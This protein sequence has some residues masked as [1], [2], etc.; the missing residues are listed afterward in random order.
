MALPRVLFL[1]IGNSCRSQMAEGYARTYGSDVMI[2]LSAGLAPAAMV[3]PVTLK[4][5]KEKN[6]DLEDAFP[7]GIEEVLKDGPADLIVNI[8]CRTLPFGVGVPVE[9]WKVRDPIGEKESVFREV[10]SEIE[11]RVMRLVLSLR[12]QNARPVAVRRPA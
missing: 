5:M 6:I 1:C 3:S 8:S 7:K 9:D 10:S 4:V 12:N 11:N 2:P